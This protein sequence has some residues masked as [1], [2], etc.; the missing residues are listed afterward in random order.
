MSATDDKQARLQLVRTLVKALHS[1]ADPDALAKR[2][3]QVLHGISAAEI[4]EVEED[5]VREGVPKEELER[6]CNLHLAMFREPLESAETVAPDWHPISILMQEHRILFGYA[7]ELAS[8]AQ[9]LSRNENAEDGL[10]RVK[11]LEAQLKASEN[12]YVREENVIFPYLEKHGITG[13]PSIMWMEHNQI[14]EIKKR[15]YS[16]V[17][18][19]AGLADRDLGERLAPAALSLAEMLGSH[20]Y[21]ENKILFPTALRVVAEEEWPELRRQFDEIGYGS[22]T[23]PA[24][25]Q[26]GPAAVS[27]AIASAEAGVVHFASGEMPLATLEALLNTLPVD[28]TFVDADDRVRYYSQ[29]A[30]RL[31]PRTNA[32]LG[33]TV[34]LCHPAKSVHV[35]NQILMDFKAG[36]RDMAEF[37]I[38]SSGKL[39]YIRYFPVRN[40]AGEYLGCL[41]V[42][43]DVTHIRELQGEKRL[44]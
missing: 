37:W 10:A 36:K 17:D 38:N 23:P 6:L 26:P 31:F 43:Q 40:A 20:F 29:T 8:L 44:L 14:R 5:L 24:A 19:S 41:E 27:M 28:I 33:R 22:Y 4:A 1:G 39:I 3:Q 35:V 25:P 12:H 9:Q 2:Y 16:S 34:Q 13:P 18:D 30:E 15:I 21:K 32:V 7:Q 42:T 11:Q